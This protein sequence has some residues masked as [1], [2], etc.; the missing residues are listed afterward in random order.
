MQDVY[1]SLH[2]HLRHDP[3]M[4][5]S[6]M[7]LV[8]ITRDLAKLLTIRQV[9]S[10]PAPDSSAGGQSGS[11]WAQPLAQS[12]T[13]AQG[14]RLDPADSAASQRA[15]QA[16]LPFG[17]AEAAGGGLSA[18][19]EDAFMPHVAMG[20]DAP[21]PRA[22]PEGRNLFLAG[23][24]SSQQDMDQVLRMCSTRGNNNTQSSPGE[25]VASLVG[26]QGVHISF[27]AA[28]LLSTQEPE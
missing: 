1:I 6:I 25:K 27:F 18:P 4:I 15:G 13:G 12:E 20:S 5:R 23:S 11:F 28:D 22:S 16:G 26:V 21:E 8:F 2:I 9:L 17:S 24:D 7:L 3:N 14:T 19:V 10:P